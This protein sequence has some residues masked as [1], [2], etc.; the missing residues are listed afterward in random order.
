MKLLKPLVLFTLLMIVTTIANAQLGVGFY[1]SN[2]G[3]YANINY[4]IKHF[5]P[6]FRIGGD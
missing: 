3:S 6:E 2:S 1:Q 4:Q 5:S